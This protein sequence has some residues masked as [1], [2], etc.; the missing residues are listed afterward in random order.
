M[1]LITLIVKTKKNKKRK[2]EKKKKEKRK[3]LNKYAREKEKT[4]YSR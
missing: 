1:N 2:R 3:I 4:F